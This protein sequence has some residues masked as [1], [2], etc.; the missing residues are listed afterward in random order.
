MSVLNSTVLERAFL[1][2]STDFQ[3]RIGNPSI[4]GYSATIARLFDPMNGDM[5]N[6]FSRLLNGIAAT[7]IDVR[8]FDNPLAILKK[9]A[10]VDWRFGF[11]ERHIAVNYIK[12]RAPH[13]DSELLLKVERPEYHEWFYSLNYENQYSFSWSRFEMMQA[14][15]A[16][17]YGFDDLLSATIT[18]LY[19]SANYDEMTTMLQVFAE[20]DHRLGGLFRYQISAAPTDESTAKE[21]LKGIRTVAGRM[22]FPSMVYNHLPVPVHSDGSRLCLF[23]LPEV[24]A[25]L[26]IDAL[27]GVFQLQKAD[28]E[29]YLYR[30]IEVPYFPI[31][32]VYAVLADEDFIFWRDIMPGMEPPFYN[33]DNRTTKY[34]YFAN[35]A[36]GCNPAAPVCVFT[37]ESGTVVPTVT[38]ATSGLSFSPNSGNVA[39]G[40][41]IQL[42]LNLAGTV[43]GDTEDMIGVEPDA[44]I[45]EV[46]GTHTNADTSTSPIQLNSR[47]YVDD[48]AILHV[49]KAGLVAGD[50]ITVTAKSA[51]IDPSGSTTDYT[52]TFT[53]T[54]V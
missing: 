50:I 51:Y 46:S 16:D 11:S 27:A 44:A 26:D 23:V 48:F 25:S 29:E 17:G 31:P 24:R 35:A 30:I 45:F 34:N 21:L 52:A 49:Q 43:T 5:F 9:S 18:Q 12:N 41:E 13:Y 53:A 10:G 42:H 32:N 54:I 39:P 14:F 22:K 47:T 2:G 8:R 7:Y 20:A 28:P 19:S 1:N 6:E 40:G 38:V 4:N 33:P 3:Q 15:A 36:V 37:T